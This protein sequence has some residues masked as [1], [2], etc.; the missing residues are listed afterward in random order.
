MTMEKANRTAPYL[1]YAVIFFVIIYVRISI[2]VEFFADFNGY[3]LSLEGL[4]S[5]PDSSWIFSDP[6]GW[7]PIIGL[8][9]VLGNIYEAIF[10][11]NILLSLIFFVGL[12]YISEKYAVAW[13]G[14]LVMTCL[15]GSLLAFVTIRATPAY[16]LVALA[17]LETNRGK[18]FKPLSLLF[19]ASLF[20]SSALLAAPGIIA[21]ILCH[22]SQILSSWAASPQKSLVV[23]ATLLVPALFLQQQL[24]DFLSIIIEFFSSSIGRF[25][26]YIPTDQ[27]GANI[28]TGERSNN[29]L[30]YAL[31]CF[32]SVVI[33]MIFS[34]KYF[35]RIRVFVLISF[36]VFSAMFF[37]PTAAFRQS[38]YW[39]I[40]MILIFPWKKFAFGGLGNAVLII[41]C[42]VL[43][44]LG[45]QGV[46]L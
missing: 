44:Y 13:Q 39:F 32:V 10:W 31:F 38:L 37:Q 8:Y 42:I 26:A 21:A 40:P 28:D 36:M 6:L 1:I 5:Q 41:G 43:G 4:L 33:F 15:F 29:D 24:S 11:G 16:L 12:V 14:I 18:Q 20:H 9:Y 46:L 25:T 34:E 22:R 7:G 45:L 35:L 23:F 3:F 2:P 27:G 17:A 19:I 30:F